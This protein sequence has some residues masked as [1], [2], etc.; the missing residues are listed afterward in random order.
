MKRKCQR[1]QCDIS[2]SYL[3]EQESFSKIKCPDCGRELEVIPICRVITISY[4]FLICIALCILPLTLFI[5]LIIEYAWIVFSYF[6]LPA[7][8]YLYKEKDEDDL[9]E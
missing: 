4:C 9:E 5:T 8:L 2:T 1:C 6:Y 3:L 7:F